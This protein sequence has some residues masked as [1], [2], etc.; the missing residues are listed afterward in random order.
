MKGQEPDQGWREGRGQGTSPSPRPTANEKSNA[1]LSGTMTPAS[2]GNRVGAERRLAGE[3]GAELTP[4]TG[5]SSSHPGSQS[6]PSP[7]KILPKVSADPGSSSCRISEGGDGGSLQGGDQVPGCN[8]GRSELGPL[9]APSRGPGPFGVAD[10]YL[11]GSDLLLGEVIGHR[12]L[13]AEPAQAAE[14]DVDELLELPALLQSPAGRGPG[15]PAAALLLLP[16][17]RRAQRR[18]IHASASG[19]LR[20]EAGSPGAR[21]PRQG[22]PDLEGWTRSALRS[23][24]AGVPGEP[25]AESAPPAAQARQQSE[26]RGDPTAAAAGAFKRQRG[27]GQGSQA[28]WDL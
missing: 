2:S 7:P 21:A 4:V 22:S 11:Q 23:A 6:A 18:S 12:A 5:S 15:A 13:G 20:A 10:P 8:S 19:Q 27:P 9:L 25:P 17:R 24:E 26:S 16:H 3:F 14:G 1:R 28:C